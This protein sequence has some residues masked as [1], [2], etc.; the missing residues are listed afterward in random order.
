MHVKTVGPVTADIM[1]VGEAPGEME[2][3]TGLP[4]KGRAGNTLNTLLSQAG[5]I[6]SQCLIANVARDRPPSNDIKHYFLDKSCKIPSPRMLEY[7]ALLQKE[8]ETYKPN[9]VIPLGNTAL[10]ALTGRKGIKHARGSVTTSTLVPGQKLLPS[11]HPQAIGYDWKLATTM[12]MDLKKALYHSRFPEVPEDKR[13]LI[14]DPTKA[15]FIELC[16]RL[17]DEKQPVAV[18]IESWGHINRIGFSNSVSWAFTLG[19]L[20][21]TIPFFPEN[22]ELEIWEW[23]G[24]VISE[25]PIIYHNAVFDLPVLFLRNGIPTYDLYM[26]TL[27]AAHI[28]WPELPKSLEY[29]TSILLDVPAWKHLSETAP[30]EYNALDALNTKAISV[31]MENLLKKR[32]LWE[33]FQREISWI[34]PASMLQLQGLF[35]DIEKKDELIK[36]AEKKSKEVDAKLLKLVGKEV[37]YNSP[38]QVKNLLYIDLELPPQYKRRKSVNEKRKITTGEDALKK[39]ARMHEVPALIIEKRKASKLI[40]TFLDI[41]V[42]PES[43]VHSSYNVT[44]T[45]FGGRWSSSK[46][47]ILTYGPGNLQNI[48]KLARSLYTVPKGYVLLE[49]DYIQAEAVV[50]AYL[51]LDTVLIKLFV[52]GFGMSASERKKGHDVHRYTAAFMYEILMEEVTKEQRRI[53]KIIRHSN[54]YDA[55]PGVLANKLDITIAQAK[56]LRKLYFQKNHLLPIWHK[57][58][59]SQLRQDRTMV[60]L[61]GRKHKFLDRW[62]DSLFRSAY[63]YIPQSSVGEL[64]SIAFRE[65]YDVLG[66]DIRI[67]LQLHD[68]IYSIIHHSEVMDVMK[69]KREIMIKEIPVGRET[70]KID[71]DFKV[72]DNWAEMEEQDISWR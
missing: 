70:M 42:S 20:K 68:A 48:P 37:N 10:W 50:V 51:C 18:D 43:R 11:Y 60:N 31:I 29:V 6:R 15:Q 69:A 9:V 41:S 4:F 12:V 65:I 32:D 17:L 56:P 72:G 49:A 2:D 46:S 67:A 64:L 52:D 59:Q 25:L 13:Q 16:Q 39:L 28:L 33:V 7:V 26:D 63:A 22:D 71:V 57:R 36:E 23:I 44:G 3:R 45:G 53:G 24:R 61:F 40:S 19:I 21:G 35:V 38:P 1:L 14:I 55:G 66:S 30:G 54:N 5:I 34:E 8:I 27:V 58:I 47:I 62:G